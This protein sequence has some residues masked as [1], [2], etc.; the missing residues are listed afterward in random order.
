MNGSWGHHSQMV[1]FSHASTVDEEDE[2]S[3]Y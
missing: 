2:L 3:S 1:G